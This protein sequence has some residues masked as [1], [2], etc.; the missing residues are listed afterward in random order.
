M[1]TTNT[2]TSVDLWRLLRGQHLVDTLMVARWY[3]REDD[4]IGGWCITVVDAP[5][6]CG[7]PSVGSFLS[8]DIARHLVD[9]HNANVQAPPP[10][11]DDRGVQLGGAAYANRWSRA[12]G[13][14]QDQVQPG[15]VVHVP[16]GADT[17]ITT[18]HRI[19]VEKISSYGVSGPRIKADG[20]PI[21]SRSVTFA[22]PDGNLEGVAEWAL[23]K[24]STVYR[25]GQPIL[26]PEGT[27]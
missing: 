13:W 3:A 7:A 25:D 19:L 15:D 24:K 20:T 27:Q 11:L 6:S 8:E 12:S 4:T 5:P 22:R 26:T 1:T 9:L 2:P 18:G 16:A 10:H 17:C 14:L 21:R 23:V